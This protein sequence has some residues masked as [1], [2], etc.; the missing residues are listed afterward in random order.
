M[1]QL[2]YG[3]VIY[4]LAAAMVLAIALPTLL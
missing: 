4:A 2:G 3:L 1:K